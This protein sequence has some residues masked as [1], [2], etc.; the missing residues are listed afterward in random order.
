MLL[1]FDPTYIKRTI[2]LGEDL[3]IEFKNGKKLELNNVP[4]DDFIK[5]LKIPKKTCH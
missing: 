3:I 4:F 5:I 2:I 1:N